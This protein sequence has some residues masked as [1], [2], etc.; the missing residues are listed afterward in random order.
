MKL[1]R[2]AMNLPAT[3]LVRVLTDRVAQR[4]QLLTEHDH[5][6]GG[7]RIRVFSYMEMIGWPPLFGYDMNRFYQ[8]PE[9]MLEMELRQRLF[10]LDNSEGDNLPGLDILPTTGN[11]WDITLFGQRIRTAPDGVPEFLPHPLA[12]KPD[13]SLLPAW[14]FNTSGDMPLLLR[15]YR[16]LRQLSAE[17]YDG[18][19]KVGFPCFYRGPLDVAIQLRGYENFIMD[20]QENPDFVRALLGRIVQERIRWNRE[21]AAWL[22]ETFPSASTFI[23]D[24]WVNPPF[25]SPTIFREFALPAFRAIQAGEGPVTGFHTCGPMVSLV[26]DLLAALPD[27]DILDVSGWNDLAQLDAVVAPGKNF[28]CQMKN[29]F[30]LSGTA[31][32]HRALLEVIKRIAA[33]RPVSVCAQAIVKL[34]DSYEEDLGR[35]N[36]FIRLAR[37]VLA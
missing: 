25:I 7:K 9:F 37:E 31:V 30:V 26:N 33:R 1:N 8:D 17:R 13:L 22:G 4:Q 15:Q 18:K 35:M 23:A 21:R 28:S 19:V 24:D 14:E 36:T 29:T 16:E 6:A 20:I 12:D 2:D 32:E 3:E 10:W 11:Y 5:A 27:I 34:H